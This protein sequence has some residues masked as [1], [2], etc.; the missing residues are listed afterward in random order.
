MMR[1]GN[2]LM[3]A[4]GVLVGLVVVQDGGVALATW[5]G[6]PLAAFLV[7]GFGNVLND[8][9]DHRIDAKAHPERALPSGRISRRGA[10]ATAAILLALGL[11]EAFVAGGCATLLFAAANAVGLVAYEATFKRMGLPGN[12]T[13]GLLVASTFA[14]GAVAAGI[15]PADWG[16]LWLL[17]AMAFLANAAREILKDVEDMPADSGERDTLPL[18]AGAGVARLLAFFLVNSAVLLSILAF[19]NSP[20]GWRVGWLV[21]LAGA[22]LLFV[23]GSSLAWMDVGQAQRVLKLAMVAALA[24]FLAGPLVP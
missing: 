22:D 3:A 21:V 7:S 13:I 8:L 1:P 24:A 12:V 15:A 19:F 20:P 4:V 23:V 14:F 6:A 18:R 5:I 9:R 17:I 10:Q 2:G 11:W 16:V